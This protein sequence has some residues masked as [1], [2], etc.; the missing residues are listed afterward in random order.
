VRRPR[1]NIIA[2]E[3]AMTV[4]PRASSD[5]MELEAYVEE[6]LRLAGL[7]IEPEWREIVLAHFEVITAA[8]KLVTEFPLDDHLEPAAVFRA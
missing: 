1:A 5:R 8:A 3:N 2:C 6:A 7:A 4:D